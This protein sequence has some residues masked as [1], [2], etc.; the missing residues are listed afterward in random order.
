MLVT[1]YAFVFTLSVGGTFV[2]SF[3][4]S[5]FVGSELIHQTFGVNDCSKSRPLLITVRRVKCRDRVPGGIYESFDSAIGF[6]P[7]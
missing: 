7:T 5:P 6:T 3:A 2:R 1:F 4:P